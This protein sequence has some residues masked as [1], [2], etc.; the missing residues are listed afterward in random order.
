MKIRLSQSELC[1]A[2]RQTLNLVDAAGVRIDARAGS[3]WVT[4]DHDLRDFVLEAGDSLTIDGNGRAI[5]QAL[6]AARVQ[7]LQPRQATRRARAGDWTTR[8]R[9][10]FRRRLLR[11]VWA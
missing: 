10:A 6:E 5:V 3:V 4:Q 8:W 1:L 11:A 2:K 7:L 9:D